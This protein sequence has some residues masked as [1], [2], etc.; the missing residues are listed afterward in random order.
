MHLGKI[1]LSFR[2]ILTSSGLKVAVRLLRVGRDQQSITKDN[3]KS[4]RRFALALTV[5]YMIGIMW[6][7]YRTK[8]TS[9][10]ARS[11]HSRARL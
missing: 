7:V 4:V 1:N 8:R 3:P 10:A 9:S 5:S 2:E 6:A 11:S